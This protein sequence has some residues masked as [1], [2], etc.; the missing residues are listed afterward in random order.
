MTWNFLPTEEQETTTTLIQL[1]D[2]RV[3]R[4]EVD[5]SYTMVKHIFK[6]LF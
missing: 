3:V 6:I 2:D 4:I 1:Q 5:S